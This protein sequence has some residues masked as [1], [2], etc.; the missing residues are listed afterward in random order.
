MARAPRPVQLAP[1]DL[2]CQ[3]CGACCYNAVQNEAEGFRDWV[4]IQPDERILR[5][6]RLK[7]RFVILADDG[8]PHLK[9][10]DQGRC[11][12]LTGQLGVHV[13][14]EIYEMRP[15]A[16]RRVEPGDESCLMYRRER[17]IDPDN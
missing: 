14:C 5:R 13:H 8:T 7:K 9:L 17:G 10:D 15:R 2:D 11:T 1:A 3:R 16:C 4:E 6:E 12:A